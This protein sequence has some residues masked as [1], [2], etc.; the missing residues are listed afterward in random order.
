MRIMGKLKE[1][2]EWSLVIIIPAM[3]FCA[4]YFGGQY[5]KLSDEAKKL[6]PIH[7]LALAIFFGCLSIAGAIQRLAD[8]IK[9]KGEH[10]WIHTPESKALMAVSE[11]IDRVRTHGVKIDTKIV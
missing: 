11:S 4:I 3:I 1:R 8:S 10:S 5:L 7:W 6:T 9:K 2:M